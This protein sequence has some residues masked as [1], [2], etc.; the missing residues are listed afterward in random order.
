MIY[1]VA[2]RRDFEAR[3]FLIGGEWGSENALH[4]HPYAV[5][6]CLEG[7]RLNEHGYLVDITAIE[8]SLD[9]ILGRIAGTTLNDL[10]EFAGLNPSVERLAELFCRSV[11]AEIA[12]TVLSAVSVK[13][14]E[15]G[16]AWAACRREI[17]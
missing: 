11:L 5:E 10:P 12:A 16:S 6:V 8:A 3:H 17:P 2:V 1:R 4:A 15:S 13:V 14:F 9:R 7:T